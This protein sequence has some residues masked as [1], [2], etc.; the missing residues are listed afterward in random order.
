MIAGLSACWRA[1][2]EMNSSAMLNSSDG[3]TD[4]CAMAAILHHKQFRSC[5]GISK[6]KMDGDELTTKTVGIFYY[7]VADFSPS[8][9]MRS[10]S[11]LRRLDGA[12]GLNATRYHRGCVRSRLSRVSV[13]ASLFGWRAIFSR[14][15]E[16]G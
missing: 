4:D 13:A 15:A 6:P 3:E 1:G 11:F 2:R 16:Y 5:I 12:F 9:R 8:R 10:C 14:M 7:C